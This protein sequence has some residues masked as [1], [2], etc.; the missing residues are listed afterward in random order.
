MFPLSPEP[1]IAWLHALPVEAIEAMLLVVCYG[2]CLLLL[3]QFG[4]AGL[5]AWIVLAVIAAN[6]QVLKEAQFAAFPEPVA[7][8]TVVFASTYLATD[9][10]AEHYG[11]Q[12]ALGGVLV[13]FAGYLLWTVLMVLTL[14]YRP[15]PGAEIQVH[16]AAIFKP[17]PALFAAGMVSYLISQSFD[18][19]VFRAVRARPGRKFLWLRTNA[20]T[21]LSALLDTVVFS[22]LAWV[23]FAPE[24]VA[25]HTLIFTY[26]L[27]TYGLRVLYSVLET[28][29]MYMSRWL[30]Q[31]APDA[32][33]RRVD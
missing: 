23:V 11:R 19:W 9:L 17:A 25:L 31:R 14:G 24:P 3:R 21:L 5:Y 33:F 22:T 10:L 28:P 4:A 7:L 6:V 20:S 27:G 26:V 18:V 13:G 30:V 29:F 2:G 1:L 16:L 15:V 8:G 12:A 32:G